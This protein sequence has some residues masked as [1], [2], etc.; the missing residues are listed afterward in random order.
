M[1]PGKHASMV[2]L[3]GEPTPN[4]THG[5]D[6]RDTCE[7]DES[8]LLMGL[9]PFYF[10]IPYRD[11]ESKMI[12]TDWCHSSLI[13]IYVYRKTILKKSRKMESIEQ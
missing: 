11:R 4:S 12:H 8:I 7:C 3:N 2:A 6:P 13:R 5:F 1:I 10:S 9:S